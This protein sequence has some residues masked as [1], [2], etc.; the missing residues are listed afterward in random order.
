MFDQRS[1]GAALQQSL[2]DMNRAYKEDFH[3]KQHLKKLP[4]RKKRIASNTFRYPQINQK[5]EDTVIIVSE[6]L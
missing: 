4:K 5:D 1:P 6:N 2:C 3:K